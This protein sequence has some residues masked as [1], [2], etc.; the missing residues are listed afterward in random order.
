M[1]TLK[2]KVVK[3]GII[4]YA[5][6]EEKLDLEPGLYY[7]RLEVLSIIK[8]TITKVCAYTAPNKYCTNEFEV[9]GKS[10]TKYC[11]EHRRKR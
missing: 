4:K 8:D 2:I 9:K 7:V 5:D 6:Q 3:N 1:I 11:K 10:N